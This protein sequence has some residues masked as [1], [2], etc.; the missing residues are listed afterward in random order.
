M[1]WACCDMD[2]NDH[3]HLSHSIACHRLPSHSVRVQQRL[4]GLEKELAAAKVAA[5][6]TPER[7]RTAARALVDEA[8]RWV[9]I[10]FCTGCGDGD[11]M[12]HCSWQLVCINVCST[13]FGWGGKVGKGRVWWAGVR[14]SSAL[15]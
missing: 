4:S 13:S 6:V 1:K 2:V 14:F 3:P 9:G 10:V 12:S 15:G 11:V 8:E 5:G 7:C